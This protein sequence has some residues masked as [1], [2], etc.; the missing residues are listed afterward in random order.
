M[1]NAWCRV[2]RGGAS[3]CL[4]LAALSGV[5][6]ARGHSF[7]TPGYHW[8][9]KLPKVA[10]VVPGKLVKLGDGVLPHVLVDAAGTAQIAYTVNPTTVGTS[11][12]HDCVLLRG[13]TGCVST[14]ALVPP[15]S[16]DPRYNE[17]N[18][19]PIPLA[20]GNELLMLSHRFPNVENLPD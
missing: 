12:L 11:V 6:V 16:G 17:D 1:G 15:E 2:A 13:Q 10:P 18:Q 3:V 19:G 20:V 5:A 4:A 8:N 7:S 14:S 9:H